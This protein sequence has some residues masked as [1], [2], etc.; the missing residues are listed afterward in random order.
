[1]RFV[2]NDGDDALLEGI[3]FPNLL[4]AAFRLERDFRVRNDGVLLALLNGLDY[5]QQGQFP[6]KYKGFF[7][8]YNSPVGLLQW[9]SH[10]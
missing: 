6:C 3:T 2:P 5:H 7:R 8:V 10:P 9:P 1:M 4:E